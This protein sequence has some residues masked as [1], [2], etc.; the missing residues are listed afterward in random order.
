MTE[1]WSSS[2]AL[3]TLILGG[4][5]PEF[6]PFIAMSKHKDIHL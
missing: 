3:S 5:L 1:R 4:S 6:G 2:E